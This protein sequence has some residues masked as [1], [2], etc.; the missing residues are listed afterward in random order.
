MYSK[1]AVLY[2]DGDGDSDDDDDDDD[3]DDIYTAEI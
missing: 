2:G 3:D 1:N